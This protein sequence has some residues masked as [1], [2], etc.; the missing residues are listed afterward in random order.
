MSSSHGFFPW[1]KLFP[2]T[3]PQGEGG[4]WGSRITT[5]EVGVQHLVFHL[6]VTVLTL[7]ILVLDF[8]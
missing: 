6:V 1:E 3:F 4:L 5:S 8:P 7:A 2:S